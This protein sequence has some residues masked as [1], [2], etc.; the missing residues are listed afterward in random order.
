[1]GKVDQKKS[2]ALLLFKLF[3]EIHLML[4]NILEGKTVDGTLLGIEADGN[5]LHGSNIV[6]RAFLVEVGKG[7]VS[8]GLVYVDGGNGRGNFLYQRKAVFKIFFICPV[9]KVF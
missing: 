2:N 8:G 6:N 1:M 5:P 3:H 7:N 9:D 4:V